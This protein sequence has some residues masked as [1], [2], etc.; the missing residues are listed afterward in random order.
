M[1]IVMEMVNDVSVVS[2]KGDPP[3]EVS[4]KEEE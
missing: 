3:V 2:T 4:G 1:D